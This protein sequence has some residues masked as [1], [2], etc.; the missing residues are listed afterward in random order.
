MKHGGIPPLT[1][2]LGFFNPK[3]LVYKIPGR[4]Q[5]QSLLAHLS[6]EA[7]GIFVFNGW[8]HISKLQCCCPEAP[9]PG[10]E[11][12]GSTPQSILKKC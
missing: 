7:P 10:L 4:R 3:L 2:S 9:P 5:T 6:F 8:V 11:L 12:E 1:P